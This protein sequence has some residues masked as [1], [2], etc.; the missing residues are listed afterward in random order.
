MTPPDV[1][2]LTGAYALDAVDDDE[3]AQVEAHLAGCEF[4]AEEV[5]GL[6]AA[7]AAL[8]EADALEPPAS[9]RSAV[10]G[11]IAT[12]PQLPAQAE[13]PQKRHGRPRWL[14]PV[15]AAAAAAV[16]AAAGLTVADQHRR[17][18]DERQRADRLS[19]LASV[20]LSRSASMPLDGGGSLAVVAVADSALVSARDLPALAGGRVY[21][22]WFVGT[23]G[24]RSAGTAD[25]RAVAVDRLLTGVGA[26]RAIAVTVEPAGG[27]AQP[28]TRT[29]V[30][31][32]VRA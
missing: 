21:Q 14:R 2:T 24:V 4:C 25:G 18:D 27:S 3:R 7:A 29:L 10:L 6:R 23:D 8:T 28:T 31:A 9:L 15:T 26:A 12:T 1:H 20:A 16:V 22:F 19:A 13:R 11:R 30:N 5:A 32:P 17:L